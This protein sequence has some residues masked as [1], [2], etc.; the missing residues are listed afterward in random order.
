MFN[1]EDPHIHNTHPHLYA[2]TRPRDHRIRPAGATGDATPSCVEAGLE[3]DLAVY[4]AANG[5]RR[6]F[7]VD[8]VFDQGVDQVAVYDDTQPLIRSVLDGA[9]RARLSGWWWL[10]AA[11]PPSTGS[12]LPL[13]VS[14]TLFCDR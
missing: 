11:W 3:G 14:L 5:T 4:D 7:K 12:N 8:R 9:R 13:C 10:S 2:R 1:P 6:V